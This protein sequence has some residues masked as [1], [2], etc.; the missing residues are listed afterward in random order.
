MQPWS[1]ITAGVELAGQCLVCHWGPFSSL[2]RLTLGTE[3]KNPI[4]LARKILDYSTKPMAL[5]RVPPNL[6]VAQGATDFAFEHNFPVLPHDY[7]ISSGARE[8]WLKWKRDLETAEQQLI[9]QRTE[10]MDLAQEKNRRRA[11]DSPQPFDSD[12]ITLTTTTTSPPPPATSIALDFGSLPP[13]MK[14]LI[15]SAADTPKA[16]PLIDMSN[17]TDHPPLALKDL[18][19]FRPL[20]RSPLSQV[21]QQDGS[22]R[23]TV[24]RLDSMTIDSSALGNGSS[25]KR[26]R[27]QDGSEDYTV[28]GDEEGN[29]SP[30]KRSRREGS[31]EDSNRSPKSPESLQLPEE[32][33]SPP[34]FPTNPHIDC[35]PFPTKPAPTTVNETNASTKPPSLL[36][37]LPEITIRRASNINPDHI[38]NKEAVFVGKGVQDGKDSKHIKEPKQLNKDSHG[39]DMITDTVGAIA[40]DCYGNIAAGSSSGGIGM[41]HR[42]RTGP[43]ALVG[44]GTAVVPID[45]DDHDRASV[46]VV[47]SGTGEHMATTMA[48]ATAADRI[49]NSMR[50]KKGG[51]M[52]ECTEDEAIQAMIEHEFMSMFCFY[53][54]HPFKD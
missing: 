3:I 38:P 22:G 32:T 35:F 17:Y 54:Y 23:P 39:D 26:N 4:S 8:R 34:L 37:P 7:L 24:D 12:D 41:K 25:Q 36:V 1:I 49:Y 20:V 19:N 9:E 28:S 40:V 47:T 43:A 13:P 50:R 11:L 2:N 51:L 18:P 42:G 6:L 30:S 53:P 29:K 27:G 46:A 48:A 15:A 5:Q 52:E 21:V 14:P 10:E 44:I 33:S 45:P 31:S 16:S